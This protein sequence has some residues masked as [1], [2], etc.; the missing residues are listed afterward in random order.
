MVNRRGDAENYLDEWMLEAVALIKSLKMYR[1][2]GIL[3]L[4]AIF[5]VT[6]LNNPPLIGLD[7]WGAK[8]MDGKYL[9]S[10]LYW[11][12]IS[13]F[14]LL[15]WNMILFYHINNYRNTQ[16]KIGITFIAIATFIG[17]VTM[18]QPVLWFGFTLMQF[19]PYMEPFSREFRGHTLPMMTNGVMFFFAAAVVA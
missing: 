6:V 18:A 9:P 15:T 3:L 14:W 10:S 5:S 7:D 1:V 8:W 11:T 2:P 17:Y 13:F 4:V 16:M 19:M 12:V